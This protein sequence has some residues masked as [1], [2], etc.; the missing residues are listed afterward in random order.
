M[1]MT[2]DEKTIELLTDILVGFEQGYHIAPS[3]ERISVLH[4]VIDAMR[5]YQKIEK[6][7]EAWNDMNSFDSMK[8]ISEVLED[9][10]DER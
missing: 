4:K 3:K 7:I 5:K 2:I 6:I 1:G 10:V 9:G 8:Q